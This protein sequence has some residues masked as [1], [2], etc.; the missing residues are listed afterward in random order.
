M[1]VLGPRSRVLSSLAGRVGWVAHLRRRVPARVM[2]ARA[3]E[4]SVTRRTSRVVTSNTRPTYRAGLVVG[5]APGERS[6]LRDLIASLR[7]YEGDDIKVVVAD[8]LTGEYP[9]DAVRE[10]FPGVDFVRPLIASGTGVAPFHAIQPA[11]IHLARSYTLPVILKCDPDT[12]IIGSGAFDRAIARFEQNPGLGIIGR[13]V[14]DPAHPVDPRWVIWMAHPELR[15]SRA[16]RRLVH[17]AEASGDGLD[18]AQGG[19]CFYSAAAV[20]AALQKGLMPYR[21]PQWSLQG[22]DVLSGLLIQ[23]AGF[24][25]EPF[26]LGSPIA[27]ETD[28]L[29]GEPEDLLAAGATIVHSV[30]RSPAG[31]NEAQIREMFRAQRA[32]PS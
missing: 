21:Q 26:G 13:T 31:L 24:T 27:T 29:P 28:Q 25:V 11:L 20:A 12:L 32:R 6:G 14:C 3:A 15:W 18:F 16:F 1:G 4:F 30:R 7:R 8:D 2:K 9:D 17:S 5:V 19:A 10:E 23:A 22:Q